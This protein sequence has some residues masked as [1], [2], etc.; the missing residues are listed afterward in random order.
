MIKPHGADALMPLFVDDQVAHADLLAESKTLEQVRISSATA[1][2]AVML[3]GGYFTPLAGYMTKADAVQVAENMHTT[4]G[5]FFPVPV[6]NLLASASFEVGQRIALTDPNVEGNP[7]IAVQ[8]IESID[9]F[10]TEELSDVAQAVFGTLDHH[11]PGVS[12]FLNQGQFAVSGPIEVLNF[13]YFEVEFADTF[14]T[15]VQIRAEIEQHVNNAAVCSGG[16]HGHF[17]QFLMR[18]MHG[19]A[20]LK[21]HYFLPIT[22]FDL[23]PNLDCGAKSVCKFNLKIT[24]VKYFNR[25]RNSELTLV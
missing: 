15:A 1:A 13:S 14:R 22:L 16:L 21:C 19:V 7:V 25:A 2:N 9:E 8:T 12:A 11:H 17:A 4:N 10:S 5:V 18:A 3:G 20:G 6:M 23:C 24:K